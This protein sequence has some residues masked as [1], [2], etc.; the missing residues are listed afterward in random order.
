MNLRH[1]LSIS[2]I[3][4]ITFACTS[5]DQYK[6]MAERELASG[7]RYDSLFL[8]I[9][10]GMEK[11]DFYAHCWELNKQGILRQGNRNATVMME[12]K[13]ELPLPADMNFYPKFY[14][15]KI[16]EMP[17][18]YGY[19]AFAPWNKQTFADSLQL[20]VRKLYE[21]VYGEGFLTIEHPEKGKAFVKVDGNR[22]ISIFKLS[23][24]LVKVLFTDLS[25]EEAL[26]AE[27][28]LIQEKLEAATQQ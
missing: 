24:N 28:E 23:D 7:E 15:D 4:L 3:S 26:Q 8:D 25:A 6:R 11:K 9:Y 13:E 1:I 22:R 18:T 12:L 2:V 19:Q 27:K 17:V 10:F 21:K 16:Y 14:E 20:E 5:G